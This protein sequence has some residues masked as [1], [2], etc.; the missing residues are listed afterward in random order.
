MY[1]VKGTRMMKKVFL[2][3]EIMKCLKEKESI[4]YG[5]IQ[6]LYSICESILS[7]IPKQFPNYTLHDI[8][9]SIRVIGYMNELV[10]ECISNFS[11]LQ[12]ALIVYSGLLHDI[13]MFVSDD[14]K[15]DLY[16]KFERVNYKFSRM[17]S[18]EKV[19]YL[20]EY[21]R[22]N[23]GKRVTDA[24][25]Y[26]INDS[27]K[28][29]SLL[30]VGSS[31]SYDLTDLISK[32]CQSHTE[33]CDWIIQNLP[34]NCEY[35]D[36]V[37]N[38]Q[39]IA[40]LLRIGDALDIDDRR[41]PYLLYKLLNPQ[42]IS[43]TEW[44][45]HIPVTNYNKIRKV[46]DFYR[47]TFS[48]E[49]KE[50]NIYRKIMEYIDWIDSDL[51]KMIEISSTFQPCYQLNI[52]K[53]IHRNIVPHGFSSELLRFRLDYNQIIKLLMGEKIYGNKRDGLR[54]LLQNAIDAV[55]LMNNIHY[56]IV[57]YGLNSY[58]PEIRIIVNKDKNSFEIFDNG[59]GMSEEIL[60]KYFFNVGNSYYTSEEF[61]GFNYQYEP[62]GHFGIGFLSCFMLSSKIKLETKYYNSKDKIQM[63][64]DKESPYITKLDKDKKDAYLEHGTKIILKYD[65]II[66][67]IFKDDNDIVNYVRELLIIDGFNIFFVNQNSRKIIE[68]KSPQL[69]N[70]YE[71]EDEQIDF[72]Y[73]LEPTIS[74]KFNIFNFFKNN[75][76]AFIV[77]YSDDYDEM[78]CVCLAYYEESLTE[79]EVAIQSEEKEL[80]AILN[81]TEDISDLNISNFI[82]D[83]LLNND[84][85]RTGKHIDYDSIRELLESYVYGF[86]N[87]DM[88]EWYDIPIILNQNVFNSFINCVEN[89]G[90]DD[91]IRQYSSDI[92]Y[93]SIL[94]EENMTDELVLEIVDYYLELNGNLDNPIDVTYYQKYPISPMKRSIKLLGISH[95]NYYLQLENSNKKMDAHYYL[96]G[97][98]IND[99]TITPY[100]TI[101]GINPKNIYLNIK[102]GMY[103]TDVSRNNFDSD[104][105]K[106]LLNKILYMVYQDIIEKDILDP[107]EVELVKDFLD[108]L[109]YNGTEI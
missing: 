95:T 3:Y 75:E 26:D 56:Q 72:K 25:N 109:Y 106:K 82:I 98:R 76:D 32:I 5:K 43:N 54:E 29:K 21:I 100:Y 74:V 66:P 65:E 59:T 15:F 73:D 20:K 53:S 4:Y 22:K 13:G 49:C 14:E 51:Q 60:E 23:H 85:R 19:S 69:E 40:F 6:D 70:S 61:S 89:E 64:F 9:H 91:A 46:E 58:V 93:I 63:L 39:Y 99:E 62:I 8:G 12:L 92:C 96:K 10:K 7:E 45:K 2:E 17:T 104:S 102:K 88:L 31:L 81:G 41:A 79:L 16:R 35:A 30:F 77:K 71:V 1:L 18:D 97:I 78:E 105:R 87:N 28:I 36:D 86:I 107:I 50:L 44:K 37:V 108:E 103:D 52:E 94:T 80:E 83:I 101:K 24:L 34:S 47:I 33:S 27:T 42:G 48:G 11:E 67:Y 68:I 84:W 57:D 38:P 55:K 90:I